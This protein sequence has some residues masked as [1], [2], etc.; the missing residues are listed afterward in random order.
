MLKNEIF[1]TLL[2]LLPQ[3]A[4]NTGI[5]ML[6]ITFICVIFN[7]TVHKAFLLNTP[8]GWGGGRFWVLGL[9]NPSQFVFENG[10]FWQ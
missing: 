7:T 2:H 5:L 10:R 3:R 6:C 8:G 9:S 4:L 1:G